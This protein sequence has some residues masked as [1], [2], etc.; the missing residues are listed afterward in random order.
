M[1]SNYKE[2]CREV[3]GENEA[4]PNVKHLSAPFEIKEVTDEGRIEGYGSTFGGKPDGH[5]DVVVEGAFSETIEDGGRNGNGIFPMLWSHDT[6]QP[7][8]MWDDI[9]ENKKGLKLGGGFVMEVQKARETHAL[10]KANVIN[11]LSIGWDFI[12]D[13]KGHILDGAVEWDDKKNIRYLKRIELWEISPVVFG[14]NRR[15]RITEVKAM[16]EAAKTPR[17]M[18]A[19]L[20]DCGLSKKASQYI[21]SLCKGALRDS[22][23]TNNQLELILSGLSKTNAGLDVYNKIYT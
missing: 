5:G 16:V 15:A 11:G 14:S 19:A 20:R 9:S 21:V 7:I 2:F 8:G 23:K 12:R 1:N 10:A 6:T 4:G 18:E 22:E 13:S 17:E 3:D